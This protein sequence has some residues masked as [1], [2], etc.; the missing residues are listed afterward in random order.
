MW[1]FDRFETYF[2]YI[3]EEFNSMG[4]NISEVPVLGKYLSYPFRKTSTFLANLKTSSKYAS[5]WCDETQRDLNNIWNSALNWIS[6]LWEETERIWDRIGAI[7]ILTK[8]VIIG[9]IEPLMEDIRRY[10]E[11]LL[12]NT[13]SVFDGL[14]KDITRD[15]NSFQDRFDALP[16]WFE[17]RLNNA[18]NKIL[19]WVEDSLITI[20]ERVMEREKE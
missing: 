8:D 11:H 17:E 19:L 14:I 5:L 20:I 1:F 18:K 16:T 3:E 9:W 6:E 12:S 15:I 2:G 4:N 13:I 7:P 10:A